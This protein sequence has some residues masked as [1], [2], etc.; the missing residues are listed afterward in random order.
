MSEE[1][2]VRLI[3]FLLSGEVKGKVLLSGYANPLYARLEEA[4]WARVDFRTACHAAG[5]TV[6]TGILGK[7]AA[8]AMQPRIESVWLDPRTAKE[9]GIQSGKLFGHSEL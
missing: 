1:D 7:G 3:D 4:G 6:G 9:L 8:T 2:H 5:R